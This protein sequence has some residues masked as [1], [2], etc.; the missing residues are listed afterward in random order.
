MWNRFFSFLTF[1]ID[2]DVEEE[3]EENDEGEWNLSVCEAVRYMREF[4]FHFEIW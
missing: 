3:E 2:P 1:R 4:S